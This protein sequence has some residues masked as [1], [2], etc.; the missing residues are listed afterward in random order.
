MK[1]MSNYLLPHSIINGAVFHPE[2][3]AFRCGNKAVTYGELLLEMNQVSNLL[4]QLGVKKGDRIGVYLNRSL[5]SAI[6][7][8][9]IMNAGAAYVPLDPHAPASRTAFLIEDCQIA[10]LIT[11]GAQRR[12]L[13]HLMEYKPKP[14][15]S[16]IGSKGDWEIDTYSWEEVKSQPTT[17]PNVRILASDLAYIM[18]TSG[19]TGQPKGIMH[20]HYSGLSYAKLS[21]T[22]YQLNET[23]CVANHAPLHFD[24]STLGYFTAPLVG[25]TTV[26]IPDAYTKMPVSLA[27]LMEKEQITVWYSV[28]LA[29]VQLV[30]NNLL[31]KHNYSS[32]RWV[33]FGGEPFPI[34]YLHALVNAW[35]QAT[36]SNVYGPAEVNQCTFYNFSKTL[37]V[38]TT[39][40]LGDVWDNTDYLILNQQDQPVPKGEVGELLIRSATR[41]MGYWNQPKL[42][43]K[44]YFKRKSVGQESVFYRTGDLVKLNAQD[45]L[46]FLGRKDRQVKLRGYRIE[47]DEVEAI[48]SSHKAIKEVAIFTLRDEKEELQIAG[49]VVVH[50]EANTEVKAL[51][52]FAAQYLPKYAVPQLIYFSETIPRISTGKT[53]Y[54]QLTKEYT[55]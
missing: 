15:K 32:I 8:Y 44:S 43:E 54:L 53:N 48:F 13:A 50:E 49:L 47:L 35:P 9:G 24:I 3:E 25:A 30:T 28:P 11:N 19:S 38:E 14:L 39:V 12:Q 26:I 21:A 36:F 55:V 7:I 20:S 51:Q 1:F 27:Q 29:L 17:A 10:H 2:K 41:M 42:T 45:Q 23:D 5:A 31:E 37:E 40:P 34:K 33:L 52:D 46:L 4:L 18:Y 16:I 22:L 6:A